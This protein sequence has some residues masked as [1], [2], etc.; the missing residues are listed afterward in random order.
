MAQEHVHQC[1]IMT[2]ATNYMT[3]CINTIPHML[4]CTTTLQYE[5][6]Y[7]PVT[8]LYPT[9]AYAAIRNHDM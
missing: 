1:G 9:A 3:L 4:S 6:Q 5:Q 7:R 2:W 8:Q